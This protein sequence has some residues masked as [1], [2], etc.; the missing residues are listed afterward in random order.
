MKIQKEKANIIYESRYD[1]PLGKIIMKSADGKKL[2]GLYFEGQKYFN[3]T[4]E[5]RR[6]AALDN[7]APASCAPPSRIT[8]AI[9]AET[10]RWL[11]VYFSGKKPC[12]TPPLDLQGTD[13]RRDVWEIL[14]KI[15]YGKTVSYGD[16]ANKIANSRGIEKMSNRAVGGAVGHNPVAIIVPCHRVVG[17][18]GSLTGYGG[19]IE[20]KIKLL[21]LE[22]VDMTN[23]FIPSKGTAL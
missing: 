14:L 2:C 18:N 8:P 15:G 19:G 1:S 20:R 4:E 21:E 13:F 16:I 12:F 23:F 10:K 6:L 22:Q 5:P 3:E 11:D 7:D 17:A 9:F